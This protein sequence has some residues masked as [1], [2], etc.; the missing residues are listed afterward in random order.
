MRKKF[1]IVLA[2]VLLALLAAGLVACNPPQPDTIIVDPDNTQNAANSVSKAYAWNKIY[3]GIKAVG[4][5]D[6]TFI[7][8]DLGF[9]FS[10]ERNGIG[11]EYIISARGSIDIYDNT[12]SRLSVEIIKDDDGAQTVLLGIY[13]KYSAELQCGILYGDFRELSGGTKVLKVTDINMAQF[14]QVMVRVLGELNLTDTIDNLLQTD[15]LG[16]P[17]TGWITNV[18]FGE[19]Q[20]FDNGNGSE[21]VAV[22]LELTDI[23]DIALGAVGGLLKDYQDILNAVRDIIGI[24]LTNLQALIPAATGSFEVNLQNNV[25]TGMEVKLDIYHPNEISTVTLGVNKIDL[26]GVPADIT[27]PEIAETDLQPFSFTTLSLDLEAYLITA[28]RTITIAGIEDAFGTLLSSLLASITNTELA[29]K[30][31]NFV[32]ATYKLDLTLDAEIDLTN[33]DNTNIMLE[34]FGLG[35]TST[36]RAGLY[37]IGQDKT[38]YVDLSGILG[39]GA[40]YKIENVDVVQIIWDAINNLVEGMAGEADSTATTAQTIGAFFEQYI[41]SDIDDLGAY[42]EYLIATGAVAQSVRYAGG[43]EATTAEVDFAALISAVLSNIEVVMGEGIFSVERLTLT[44]AGDV[45]SEI[46]GM[47]SEGARLPIDLVKLEYENSE[48]TFDILFGGILEGFSAHVIVGITYGSLSDEEIMRSTLAGVRETRNTYLPMSE[49]GGLDL[50]N[51]YASMR[52]NLNIYTLSQELTKIRYENIDSP[53]TMLLELL[54]RVAGTNN[55]NLTM[56]IEAN[57]NLK[58]FIDS[59]FHL[60]IND[61]EDLTYIDIYFA[62][63]TIYLDASYFGLQKVKVNISGFMVDESAS[64]AD[65]DGGS[66]ID[67]MAVIAAMVGQ[68]NLGTDYMELLLADRI[69]S[70]ILSLI[71]S[72][73]MDHLDLGGEEDFDGGIRIS[74]GDGLNLNKISVYIF[75]SSGSNFDMGISLSE[76]AISIV[77][78]DIIPPAYIPINDPDYSGTRYLYDE[79]T[80]LYSANP[81]GDYMENYYADFVADPNVWV[82]IAGSMSLNIVPGLIDLSSGLEQ[83]LA[84][85][86][87][88]SDM[89]IGSIT[90]EEQINE[91]FNI[92][93]EANLDLEPIIRKLQTGTYTTVG[94]ETQLLISL[95]R[96]MP[97]QEVE[98]LLGIYYKGGILYLD[99]AMLGIQKVAVEFDIFELLMK[100]FFPEDEEE[101]GEATGT[102]ST[103]FTN[104]SGELENY[105]IALLISLALTDENVVISIIDGLT[106]LVLNYIGFGFPEIIAEIEF[107]WIDS[108]EVDPIS[109]EPLY[110]AGLYIYGAI[111]DDQGDEKISIGLNIDQ[112]EIAFESRNISKTVFGPEYTLIQFTDEDGNI[113]IPGIYFETTGFIDATAYDNDLGN[114]DWKVGTWLESI[115][116][117]EDAGLDN[118]LK[119]LLFGFDIHSE[120]DVTLGFKISLMLRLKPANINSPD[121]SIGDLLDFDYILTHSD[122]AVELWNG[123]VGSEVSEKIMSVYLIY[124]GEN[125]LDVPYSTLYLDIDTNLISDVHVKMEGFSLA[126]LLGFLSGDEYARVFEL[127]TDDTEAQWTPFDDPTGETPVFESS[128]PLIATAGDYVGGVLTITLLGAAGETV[129]TATKGDQT[130]RAKV[131]VTQPA[132]PAEEEEE[133]EVPAETRD[134]ISMLATLISGGI[135]SITM[136][137]DGVMINLGAKFVGVVLGLFLPNIYYE[138]EEGN[139]AMVEM[140]ELNPDR[141]FISFNWTTKEMVA[142]FGVD[143]LALAI[144]I[145]GVS[146]ALYESPV[147]NVVAANYIDITE[148]SQFSLA[149]TMSI[150]FLLKGTGS[151]PIQIDDYV[152]AFLANFALDFGLEI[153][154]DIYF[155]L[156]LE[157]EANLNLNNIAGT[158]LFMQLVNNNTGE[159]LIGLYLLGDTLYINM[160]MLSEQNV[161]LHGISV[162]QLVNDALR[163]LVDKATTTVTEATGTNDPQPNYERALEIIFAFAKNEISL[164]LTQNLIIALISYLVNM[165][166]PEGER[167]DLDDIFYGDNAIADLGMSLE[168]NIN[169]LTPSLELS[170]DS[171][172][173]ALSFKIVK[174]YFTTKLN[175][176][177]F[178][179]NDNIV[180]GEDW[181]GLYIVYNEHYIEIVSQKRYTR[182]GEIYAQDD[183]GV[184]LRVSNDPEV[185]IELDSGTVKYNKERTT[186]EKIEE[187]ILGVE[188]NS[189]DNQPNLFF[190]VDL[191]LDYSLDATYALL[192]EDEAMLLP[193][194]ARYTKRL[195]DGRFVQDNN[196]LY[197]KVP[198]EFQTLLDAVLNLD[199]LSDLKSTVIRPGDGT[200]SDVTL[201]DLLARLAL[202]IYIDDP[203]NSTIK[204]SMYGNVDLEKL[205]IMNLLSGT[206][207]LA[208]IDFSLAALFDALE[209]GL[210][211]TVGQGANQKQIKI[212][213]VDKLLYLDLT[214]IAGPRIKLDIFSLI[215]GDL[216]GGGEAVSTDGETENSIVAQVLNAIIKVA[217]I[218]A[219][220]VAGGVYS[221]F[222]SLNV[223]FNSDLIPAL[224]TLFSR[225]SIFDMSGYALDEDLSGLF[226]KFSDDRFGGPSISL[227]LH[228]VQGLEVRLT[229]ATGI[230][231]DLGSSNAVLTDVEKLQYADLTDFKTQTYNFSVIGYI[232]N[233]AED[234]ATYDLSGLFAS[235]FGDMLFE[236]RSAGEYYDA[237]AFRLGANVNLADIYLEYLTGKDVYGLIGEGE[238]YEGQRYSFNELTRQ[239]VPDD[240]GNYK[241]VSAKP[242]FRDF[243][244]RS[245]LDTL[246][247]ALELLQLSSRNELVY[248]E[249]GNEIVLGG[250]YLHGG[251]LYLNGSILFE[252]APISYVPNVFDIIEGLIEPSSALLDGEA[253]GT[254]DGDVEVDAGNDAVL[255]LIFSDPSIRI[256]LTKSFIS[257]LLGT[258]YPDLGAIDDIFDKLSIDLSFD[259]GLISFEPVD[260]STLWSGDRFSHYYEDAAGSY[261]YVNGRFT[262]VGAEYEGTRYSYDAE[263]F[264]PN[265]LGEYKIAESQDY[266]MLDFSEVY[267]GPKYNYDYAQDNNGAYLKAGDNYYPMAG[268]PRYDDAEGLIP[269]PLGQYIL[270]HESVGIVQIQAA[271]RYK[272]DFIEVPAG[273]EGDYKLGDYGY[274]K[275]YKG[276][277]GYESEFT[278]ERFAYGYYADE[279]GDYVLV[280]LET[281]Y[282]IPNARYV[283]NADETY[284]LD[285]SGN[286]VYIVAIQSFIE[287]TPEIRYELGYYPHPDGDYKRGEASYVMILPYNERYKE[288]L[289]YS[290]NPKGEYKKVG[291]VYT[292]I[293]PEENWEGDRYTQYKN[294]FVNPQ[295]E[296]NA[297][298][299]FMRVSTQYLS[300]DEFGLSLSTNFGVFKIGFSIHGL[301]IGFGEVAQ[302]VPQNVL[303]EALPFFESTINIAAT[304]DI[305]VSMT[306]GTIDMG[307]LFYALLGDLEGLV[308][309]APEYGLGETALHLRFKIDLKLDLYSLANSELSLELFMVTSFGYEDLWLG[310]YYQGDVLYIDASKL[311]L[312]KLSISDNNFAAQLEQLLGKYLGRGI[313]IGVPLEAGSTDSDIDYDSAASL[314]LGSHRFTLTIG[315]DLVF[316]VLKLIK[317]GD[318]PLYDLVYGGI[319][320]SGT[321]DLHI[322]ILDLNSTELDFRVGIRLASGDD[323]VK[324]TAA[325]LA[326]VDPQSPDY[327]APA[328]RYKFV[329]DTSGLFKYDT[330]IGAFV[331]LRSTQMIDASL[332]FSPKKFGTDPEDTDIANYTYK[333]IPG[334]PANYDNYPKE[335]LLNLRLFDVRIAFDLEHEFALSPEEIATF[336]EYKEIEHITFNERVEITTMFK[337]GTT[338]LTEWVQVFF[339]DEDINTLRGLFN[340]DANGDGDFDDDGILSRNIYLDI[341]LDIKFAAIVNL[342]RRRAIDGSSANEQIQRWIEGDID[343][344]ALFDLF[345]SATFDITELISYINGSFVISTETPEDGLQKIIGVY[346]QGGYYARVA[347]YVPAEPEYSGQRYSRDPN[348]YSG[349][350]EDSNGQYKAVLDTARLNALPADERYSHYFENPDGAYVYENGTYVPYYEGAQGTRYSYDNINFYQNPLGDYERLTGGTYIDLSFFGI[351]YIYIDSADIRVIFNNLFGANDETV[352]TGEEEEEE[353]EEPAPITFPLLSSEITD[354]IKMFVWGFQFTSSYVSLVIQASYLNA[355]ADLLTDEDDTYEFYF[356]FN[357]RSTVR[358]NIEQAKYTFEEITDP[359]KLAD[360][361]VTKYVLTET[362]EG[363][364]VYYNGFCVLKGSLTDEQ[365]EDITGLP[366]N[367]QEVDQSYV[368]ANPGLTYHEINIITDETVALIDIL[369]YLFD[370]KLNVKFNFFDISLVPYDYVA[371]GVQF[372]PSSARYTRTPFYG[373]DDGSMSV[374]DAEYHLQVEGLY[375]PILDE[376]RYLDANGETQDNDGD[377]LQIGP[378]AFASISANQVFR[379]LTYRYTQSAAGLYIRKTNNL[380]EMMP[381]RFIEDA[382]GEFRFD[383]AT[384]RYEYIEGPYGGTRYAYID[385]V[386]L[387]DLGKISLTLEGSFN[388]NGSYS[389]TPLSDVLFG[390]LGEMSS[391][392]VV[393]DNGQPYSL[394][395]GFAVALNLDLDF[396]VKKIGTGVPLNEIISINKIDL[397]IDVWRVEDD[398]SITNLIG[399]YYYNGFL[400][401]DISFFLADGGKICIEVGE[402]AVEDLLNSLLVPKP[403]TDDEALSASEVLQGADR[404]I[405]GVYINILRNN[406]VANISIAFIRLVLTEIIGEGTAENMF[407]LLPNLMPYVSLNINPLSIVVGAKIFNEQ[408]TEELLDI[409]FTLYGFDTR[410]NLVLG[411]PDAVLPNIYVVKN[412]T[413][414]MTQEAVR[415]GFTKVATL[416]LDALLG[417]GDGEIFSLDIE[418]IKLSASLTLEANVLAGIVNWSQEF[419]EMLGE[420]VSAVLKAMASNGLTGEDAVTVVDIDLEAYIN[421]ENFMDAGKTLTEKLAGTQI[422]LSMLLR[423]TTLPW[424]DGEPQDIMVVATVLFNADGTLSIYLDLDDLGIK[425]GLGTAFTKLKFENIDLSGLFSTQNNVEALSAADIVYGEIDE[426][427]ETGLLPLDIFNVLNSIVRELKLFNHKF[428][429]NFR[430]NMIDSLLAMLTANDLLK[431]MVKFPQFDRTEFALDLNED[432]KITL[433][434][435]FEVAEGAEY[436]L[437][438][439]YYPDW[440][441]DRY[442]YNAGTQTYVLNPAGT[443]MKPGDINIYMTLGNIGLEFNTT[444]D[445]EIDAEEFMDLTSVKLNLALEGT[446]SMYGA[447]YTEDNMQ[448]VIDLSGIFEILLG[449]E[450]SLANTDLDLR[451]NDTINLEYKFGIYAYVDL[452]DL[453]TMELAFTFKEDLGGGLEKTVLSAYI[454]PKF[455]AGVYKGHDIYID[456]FLI[457][458][459]QGKLSIT[460][461]DI[462]TLLG[463]VLGGILPGAGGEAGTT[464]LGTASGIVNALLPSVFIALRPE[465]FALAINAK[466]VNAIM[467]FFQEAGGNTRRDVFPDIGDLLLELYAAEDGKVD[468][469]L[470]LKIN[471]SFYGSLDVTELSILSTGYAGSNGKTG[472]IPSPAQLA[473]FVAAFDIGNTEVLLESVGLTFNGSLALTSTGLKVGDAGYNDTINFW[474]GDL[475]AGLLKNAGLTSEDADGN[476]FEI[477]LPNGD[478]TFDLIA[479]IDLNLRALMSGGGFGGI[480]YSDIALELYFGAPIN[481]LALG[482]Y[483]LGSTR[484]TGNTPNYSVSAAAGTFADYLYIDATA[485]GLGKIKLAGFAGLIGGVGIEAPAASDATPA[486]D[487]DSLIE[488]IAA[489]VIVEENKIAFNFNGAIVARLLELLGGLG[490]NINLD[491][492]MEN[493]QLEVEFDDGL[494]AIILSAILD[495]QGTALYMAM[496]DLDISFNTGGYSLI[497]V[498]S[499]VQE[500]SY[501]YAG[502]SLGTMGAGGLVANL[503]ESLDPSMKITINKLTKDSYA[504]SDHDSIA[505]K[506]SISSGDNNAST[507]S[508]A[509]TRSPFKFDGETSNPSDPQRLKLALTVSHPMRNA[510]NYEGSGNYTLSAYLTNGNIVLMGLKGIVGTV[511]GID[512]AA[513]LEPLDIGGMMGGGGPLLDPF[514][515]A[516]G[517][518]DYYDYP[519]TG[520]VG[521]VWSKNDLPDPTKIYSWKP[522]LDN[523]IKKVSISLW[524]GYG[525]TPYKDGSTTYL[526]GSVT[527]RYSSIKLTLDKDAY[528]QL[529]CFVYYTLFSLFGE[530]LAAQMGGVVG[531]GRDTVDK[532]LR[533]FENK[534]TD[535]DRVAYMRQY[536]NVLAPAFVRS[537]VSSYDWALWAVPKR[538]ASV[539]LVFDAIFPLPWASHD[540]TVCIY[541]DS[542]ASGAT[543][544]ISAVPG[545]QSIEIYV[546]ATA[547]T[548]LNATE[549]ARIIM[550]ANSANEKMISLLEVESVSAA[551]GEVT[552][553]TS[554]TIT[555]PAQRKGTMTGGG[556]GT[557][558]IYLTAE[559]FADSKLF[560]QRAN[561]TFLD[562]TVNNK[563]SG[564]LDD[565]GGVHIVWDASSVNMTAANADNNWLAGHVYGY[566]LDNIM[567]RI[568]VYVTNAYE[569]MAIKGYYKEGGNWTTKALTVDINRNNA[570]FNVDLPDEV[571]ITFR[572]GGTKTFSTHYADE[573]YL[574]SYLP[575]VFGYNSASDATALYPA[576]L[577]TWEY[578]DFEYDLIGGTVKVYYTY[579][580]GLSQKAKNYVVVP[581]KNYK[582]NSIT[583]F[584]NATTTIN[585]FTNLN[586]FNLDTIM[587]GS[588][589]ADFNLL[590]YIQSFNSASGKYASYTVDG[591]V[592]AGSSFNGLELTW[593]LSALEKAMNKLKNIETGGW[594][595][596][597]GIDVTVKAYLGGTTFVVGEYFKNYPKDLEDGDYVYYDEA[598]G[599]IYIAQAIDVRVRVSSRIFDSFVKKE[600]PFDPYSYSELTAPGAIDRELQVNFKIDGTKTAK[601]VTDGVD[602]QMQ[603]PIVDPGLISYRGYA[604][605]DDLYATVRIGTMFSG[606]QTVKLPIK[607]RNMTASTKNLTITDTFNPEWYNAFPT[608][609][610]LF[611][612]GITHTMEIDW[613]TLRLFS[614]PTYSA[615]DELTGDAKNIYSGGIK[616]ALAEGTVRDGEGEELGLYN[617]RRQRFKFMLNVRTK[618]I[619]AIYLYDGEGDRNSLENYNA[620]SYTLNPYAY[621]QNPDQYFAD[622]GYGVQ[623]AKVRITYLY[624][625]VMQS[626]FA[627]VLEWTRNN[628]NPSYEGTDIPVSVKVGNQSL[629]FNVDVQEK[630]VANFTMDGSYIWDASDGRYEYS[631]LVSFS[632]SNTA[633]SVQFTDETSVVNAGIQWDN[634]S[635]PTKA[636]IEA[637]QFTRTIIFFPDSDIMR[638]EIQITVYVVN[639]STNLEVRSP[640]IEGA[641]LPYHLFGTLTLPQSASF[642]DQFGN[643]YNNVPLTWNS[644]EL[645]TVEEILQGS[646]LRS[647]TIISDRYQSITRSFNVHGSYT[648]KNF[649]KVGDSYTYTLSSANFYNGLPGELT[650]IVGG[651]EFTVSAEWLNVEYGPAGLATTPVY[652]KLSGGG[653]ETIT[654]A[655]A[656]ERNSVSDALVYLTVEPAQINEFAAASTFVYDPFALYDGTDKLFA[657][658]SLIPVKVGGTYI[659]GVLTGYTVHNVK[660]QYQLPEDMLLSEQYYGKTIQVPVTFDYFA[661]TVIKNMNVYVVDRTVSKI[662]N[663]LYRSVTIDPFD[664]STF[665]GLP[666]MLNASI[667]ADGTRFDFTVTWPD[668]DIITVDGG[669]YPEF[670][671]MFVYTSGQVEAVQYVNIPITVISRKIVSTQ[672]VMNGGF[673]ETNV[674]EKKQTTT[675]TYSS[676]AL[677]QIVKT[678]YDKATGLPL[679]LTFANPFAYDPSMLPQSVVLTFGNG[680]K[681]TYPVTWQLLPD[682]L[683]SVDTLHQNVKANVWSYVGA[684]V[685]GESPISVINLEMV[686][687]A[688]KITR[689]NSDIA[690]GTLDNNLSYRFYP[691]AD[692][693][694]TQVLFTY[695][696][697][698]TETVTLK[699]A[700]NIAN[701][702]EQTTLYIDGMWVPIAKLG[703]YSGYTRLYENG[704]PVAYNFE[705]SLRAYIKAAG[706]THA[707]IYSITYT[708]PID[709]VLEELTYT[710]EGGTRYVTARLGEEDLRQTLRVPVVLEKQQLVSVACSASDFDSSSTATTRSYYLE[711]KLFDPWTGEY[712]YTGEDFLKFYPVTG[713]ATFTSDDGATSWKQ[714]VDLTWNLDGVSSSYKGGVYG[715]KAIINGQGEYNFLN[716]NAKTQ[717]FIKNVTYVNRTAA[718]SE[719]GAQNSAIRNLPGYVA[720]SGSSTTWIYPYNYST[721]SMPNSLYV[722][723]DNELGVPTTLQFTV[724]GEI[725]KLGWDLNSFR[726]NY[727]GGTTT[728]YAILS[729]GNAQQRLPIVFNVK[730]KYVQLVRGIVGGVTAGSTA[731]NTGTTGNYY[732]EFNTT[733]GLGS[734]V[735]PS[736][737]TYYIRPFVPATYKLPTSYN[738]TFRTWTYNEATGF[739]EV[740]TE[741]K[742]FSYATVTIPAA[743]KY[744]WAAVPAGSAYQF[745]IKFGSQQYVTVPVAVY[746]AGITEPTTPGTTGGAN[747]SI[748]TQTS[749]L[750]TVNGVSSNTSVPVV[751]FGV[752]L[753]YNRAKTQI[754]AQHKVLFSSTSTT[755]N[756]PTAG[757]RQVVYVLKGVIGVMID[758][759]G[760]VLTTTIADSQ[761]T[762]SHSGTNHVLAVAGDTIPLAAY[763]GAYVDAVVTSTR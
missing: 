733:T 397:A 532:I 737:H 638:Q 526:P 167:V 286:Y 755:M 382:A 190:N 263:A 706:G 330:D 289:T 142:S 222:D 650:V 116:D 312:P 36:M 303:D 308:I 735:N 4:S 643:I 230:T 450:S 106:Q 564:G 110:E 158:Q 306:A 472:K 241:L 332:R 16:T 686:I 466:A 102:F 221:E 346:I 121:F 35:A 12:K 414:D 602:M 570:T 302:L 652:L 245:K 405:A 125:A 670:R 481:S 119:Q 359:E 211:L 26:S 213:L 276:V 734:V 166:K 633:T 390:L 237:V 671:A 627:Y 425:L 507:L 525:Y 524:N 218:K 135:S 145:D 384:G 178:T 242:T 495:S 555:D 155:G 98:T 569:V 538:I 712:D 360:Q 580:W 255:A 753:V 609:D 689:Y 719:S 464:S 354:I 682:K 128:N 262:A 568:P 505:T 578:K 543:G 1:I 161:V 630:V 389:E 707:F 291:A 408:G 599:L 721:P 268:K 96:E 258:L 149:V 351:P 51:I 596:Y 277:D 567:Y 181:N 122:L 282:Q 131:V 257:I 90:I 457:L 553:P 560:P 278:G 402:N 50:E 635:V 366:F 288:I 85:I 554:I 55:I 529:M 474:L 337:E 323:Y 75:A 342:L 747:A 589:P 2:V 309:E 151:Q 177:R 318:T 623:N 431:S 169:T 512:V 648:I 521:G 624:A 339:P 345:T 762:G 603:I 165:N 477:V 114:N 640:Q 68:I 741:T 304:I 281:Y 292:L 470:N 103:T 283:R 97:G 143:P 694:G 484:V 156:S 63:R 203:I 605:G 349:Y 718:I 413:N 606:Y 660:A 488:S 70:Q 573:N 451:V 604:G 195:S 584:A 243:I 696:G 84:S 157:L 150:D 58:S 217:V 212:S 612:D 443:Y 684:E 427:T 170:F 697:G 371:E 646:F 504:L 207:S 126:S 420:E 340:V 117:L 749:A 21:T 744:G 319:E 473:Q 614:K 226:V 616:Y 436:V 387:C 498:A 655:S 666:E 32:E 388:I 395:I 82:K 374:E 754:I 582:I 727:T 581:I 378:T 232:Y 593:D 56:D 95:T 658:N 370:H 704:T 74:F 305:K 3:N 668:D 461:F 325:E 574:T 164:T 620:T 631:P 209:L 677:S 519:T 613:S 709:W 338:D 61:G 216:F 112:P 73:F 724:D 236:L 454:V 716:G 577:L 693:D 546:N 24:D 173:F 271:N 429:L 6:S 419:E 59:Q 703:D 363:N 424:A 152:K 182:V 412:A 725:Y 358:I 600:L 159:V 501:G 379:V 423:S 628:F 591:N 134:M 10:L 518:N 391:L 728:V 186:T 47:F 510:S 462:A 556:A 224:M 301:N 681:R 448:N 583:R 314:L 231:V 597:K 533:E 672:F 426:E 702:N 223:H 476:D 321:I 664:T 547:T 94:N 310:L 17:I 333:L 238:N 133:E 279:N 88:T 206:G 434:F 393:G 695:P 361:K 482:I 690:S 141:S 571:R 365:L 513:L 251:A 298:Y 160:G 86:G 667:A 140:V 49:D 192:T 244:E 701:Y 264:Y 200:T 18:L 475:I 260:L 27:F 514:K 399:I 710:Y 467:K 254:A 137:N 353:D 208:D 154:D 316:Y 517:N 751:W 486:A 572:S 636:E 503:L 347:N 536:A 760:N 199:I 265:A 247:I 293:G 284:T 592:I 202:E 456:L 127:T 435:S 736:V 392:L 124:Q 331:K 92:T 440:T 168:L 511:I 104:S 193:P 634:Y 377:F 673:A 610:F 626:E 651:L 41:D 657:S 441:G 235:W 39:A 22:K 561:V 548:I 743:F 745:T 742:V 661:G 315:E 487:G 311:N 542:M 396:D 272:L 109:G 729:V 500:V 240:E 285:A 344:G 632:I 83:L 445:I 46:I 541:L 740:A 699:N 406:I 590:E 295:N 622:T 174:P 732:G 19:C 639:Y 290:L 469:S 9:S 527:Q 683:S 752:A 549:Y 726:P 607:V 326:A 214:D 248:D 540:P 138:D 585:N 356:D 530:G 415:N 489:E 705:P 294:Y 748:T 287:L 587:S 491:I 5:P 595:Y 611:S 275:L 447:S 250:I 185:Y 65:G 368:D 375:Y 52:L 680:E 558:P 273:Q 148:L 15:L 401:V 537:L 739:T 575:Q 256:S 327:V 62:Q 483:Y 176:E 270:I 100:V 700:Y 343:F 25:F 115:L 430:N 438:N 146:I 132:P 64:T 594:D 615:Q 234:E 763:A 497:D 691:Y 410:S 188:F 67:F 144:G 502:I 452:D 566:V 528:N 645:P 38:V 215:G 34:L 398:D 191:Y 757:G 42:V 153:L 665:A 194:E 123:I 197:Q 341:A 550:Q 403:E 756:L 7:N 534:T 588:V 180:T 324:M 539:S 253:I 307:E 233:G 465:Y 659:D 33:N 619:S 562:G 69:L 647:A 229:M 362:V 509:L 40:R 299:S 261:G 496:S 723:V 352:G 535:A 45:I 460:N 274:V 480:L 31:I 93:V 432:L 492:P 494:N 598:R 53:T 113:A 649:T 266:L 520:K 644:Y 421:I 531:G 267:E 637:G 601:W 750:L 57:L 687:S 515:I 336:L 653:F 608:I 120:I 249:F 205:G 48:L 411:P 738:V 459:E 458:G 617:G 417:E 557:K 210:N 746:S 23:L 545:I 674:L 76:I 675:Y 586:A 708:M 679:T 79:T 372:V 731:V 246:E 44:L 280:G 383:A 108:V 99:I 551:S 720:L 471:D 490:L 8:F 367:V 576:G 629:A 252:N 60:S 334:D 329:P 227:V 198:A 81:L 692:F 320:A 187:A 730:R 129:I 373:E 642:T 175:P 163:G 449:A 442:S 317:L 313:D 508:I 364:Y 563:G 11:P 499:I 678:V 37:Y 715:A 91:T 618:K 565:L 717:T 196:G 87:L 685:A 184:F 228:S 77:G 453:T 269:N 30:P 118:L 516:K 350:R 300:L 136:N 322:D 676:A 400:Y 758:K 29:N 559:Y 296:Y 201:G 468:L 189:L 761:I 625:G 172:L 179:L 404:A 656:S 72:S 328:M 385:Y 422:Q 418:S 66:G 641:I 162:A 698:A 259:K 437:I 54:I 239:Y 225:D 544:D 654:P 669:S 439:E 20:V 552:P 171:S 107:R 28:D 355:V 369:L 386:D 522:Q 381:P 220:T 409:N 147:A 219:K 43:G 479:K 714:T 722:T 463:G 13:Y 89:G 111:L 478:L 78:D 71:D 621:D 444:S 348:E 204:I 380:I 139:I 662:T 394:E 688:F 105:D 433:D 101:D 663:P 506:Q 130:V 183:F 14:A 759:N 297:E 376:L 428:S 446:F 335:L 416:N 579:Q 485:F 80:G 493:L 523:L 357:N 455:E 711:N 407:G 713:L